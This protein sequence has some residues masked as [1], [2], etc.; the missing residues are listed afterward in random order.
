VLL[1]P[2]VA[3][4]A[5]IAYLAIGAR[6]GS[7]TYINAAVAVVM[8]AGLTAY[9]FAVAPRLD[10][11][12]LTLM[13]LHLPLLAWAAVGLTVLGWRSSAQSRFAF[14]AKSIETIGTAGVF[15]IAGG[16]FVGITYG[17]F[18]ALG[19]D[20]PNP[21]L[22][23]LVAGGAGLIPLFAVASVYD[24]AVSPAAQEFG[25]GLGKILTVLMR[26]LLALSL[27]VLVIYILVIPFY[28]TEPFFQRDVLII[29]NVMLFGILGL[30]IGVTPLSLDDLAP[31]YQTLL[32]A[33]V[34]TLA[35][36]VVLV[37]LYALAATVYRTAIGSFTPNRVTVLGWNVINIG[38]LIALLVRQLRLGRTG[39][40]GWV[41]AAQSVIGWGAIAYVVWAAFVLLALPWL[42]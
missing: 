1:A 3:A 22:R 14:L 17:L 36:L 10:T 33:G 24:P 39:R 35:A 19:A 41:L 31:R 30:L 27:V 12:H 26:A 38:I 28:F 9:V 7:A 11:T 21:L 34:V 4:V 37:S 13:V 18:E 2:P 40:D 16:I 25:Q 8:L 6:H 32:R 29:Y 5:L 15:S 42:L 20:I 23:L